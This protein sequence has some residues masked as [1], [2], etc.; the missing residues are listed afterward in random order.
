MV[1]PVPHN[2]DAAIA[3]ALEASTV[4]IKAAREAS[5]H[6][7]AAVRTASATAADAAARAR[8]KTWWQMSAQIAVWIVLVLLA[9]G[10]VNTRLQVLEVKDTRI[11][12][13]IAEMRADIKVLL[14][15]SQAKE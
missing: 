15:L 2:G 9:Y 14:R 5:E 6:A 4:A 3:A 7:A 10:T 8:T 11:A 13:D 12:Q 1:E